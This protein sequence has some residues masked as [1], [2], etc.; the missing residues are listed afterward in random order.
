MVLYLRAWVDDAG[1]VSA[2]WLAWVRERIA[3]G[4]WSLLE[5]FRS[6]LFGLRGRG[7]WDEANRLAQAT[8]EL[9]G[10]SAVEGAE[11]AR[12][13][14]KWER[15]NPVGAIQV[16]DWQTAEAISRRELQ[17]C[18]LRQGGPWAIIIAAGRGGPTPPELVQTL[19]QHGIDSVD[20]YGLFG[21][22]LVARE[23]A[24]AR[25]AGKAFAAL[26]KS[27]AYWANSPYF[28]IDIWEHDACWDGLRD[29]SEFKRLFAAKRRRI[30]PIYGMLHYFP[31]W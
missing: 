11:Q 17:E 6:V 2:G 10:A 19:E 23:A 7:L 21:W 27:L 25:D 30:G 16:K 28:Y 13:P 26:E 29:R 3:A 5:Q 14:W 9:L 8:W 22:Y 15:F 31:G 12:T 1:S 20:E 18:G 24:F 4:E